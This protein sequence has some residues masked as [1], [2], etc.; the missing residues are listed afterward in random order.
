MFK[1]ISQ[2]IATVMTL[3]ALLMLPYYVGLNVVSDGFSKSPEITANSAY[4]SNVLGISDLS[5][6]EQNTNTFEINSLA[7]YINYTFGF[8]ALISVFSFVK[9]KI[10]KK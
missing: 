5:F 3:L 7:N 4:N 10:S 9:Y 1:G 6:T 8:L 2:I